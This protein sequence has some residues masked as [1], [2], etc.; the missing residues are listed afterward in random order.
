MGH[1]YYYRDTHTHL[2]CVCLGR[3]CVHIREFVFFIAEAHHLIQKNS[4][5]N[6]SGL[7]RNFCLSIMARMWREVCVVMPAAAVAPRRTDA[8]VNKC[9][10]SNKCLKTV[11]YVNYPKYNENEEQT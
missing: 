4:I 3:M 5:K 7:F 6:V 10:K 2:F 1:L 11:L 8:C 9:D